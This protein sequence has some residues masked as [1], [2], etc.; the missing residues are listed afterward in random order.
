M[1]ALLRH[2][3]LAERFQQVDGKPVRRPTAGIDAGQFAGFRIPVN[4]E[5]ISAHAATFGFHHTEHRVGRDGC[6]H[7]RSAPCQHLR[8]RLGSQRLAGGDDAAI[9]DDH[10]ARLGSILC[11][12]RC[13][14]HK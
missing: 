1:N 4:G 12:Q 2:G 10:R 14:K 8:P 5:E 6:I 7:S 11:L 13:V 9:A 3:G